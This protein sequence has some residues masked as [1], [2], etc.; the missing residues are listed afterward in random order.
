MGPKGE[1]Q[2]TFHSRGFSSTITT[3]KASDFA[4]LHFETQ[5]LQHLLIFGYKTDFIGFLKIRNF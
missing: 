2:N 5:P 1:S 3:K 4:W